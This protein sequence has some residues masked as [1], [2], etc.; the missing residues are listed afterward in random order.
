MSGPVVFITTY[1]IKEGELERF[2]AIL[3]QLLDALEAE[4]PET[5]AINAYVN[6]DG[7]EA[8]IVQF[9]QDAESIKRFWRILHQRTGRSLDDLATTTGVHVYG[10][11][12]DIAI[13]RTRHSTGSGAGVAVLPRHVGGFTRSVQTNGS[14][15]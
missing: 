13:E 14:R 1:A 8:S 5:L 7:T 15:P 3:R 4:E 12:G 6:A 10:S 2:E 11:L 9:T